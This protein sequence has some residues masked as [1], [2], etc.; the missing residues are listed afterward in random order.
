[1]LK[2]ENKT[3]KKNAREKKFPRSAAEKVLSFN[4]EEKKKNHQTY[5]W[6]AAS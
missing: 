3:L 2:Y 4:L 5:N 1:L 6:Y